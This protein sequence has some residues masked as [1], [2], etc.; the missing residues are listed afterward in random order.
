MSRGSRSTTS[1]THRASSSPTS[2][3]QSTASSPSIHRSAEPSGCPERGSSRR[4]CHASHRSCTGGPDRAH[5]SST[6]STGSPTGRALTRSA[7]CWSTCRAGSR[8]CWLRERCPTCRSGVCARTGACSRSGAPSWRSTRRRHRRWP[9]VS[10]TGSS[11]SR[12]RR[13]RIAPRGGRRPSSWRRWDR[14]ETP[15]LRSARSRSR[16]ATGT[17]PSTCG[18]SCG[19]SSTTATSRC[20][21]GRRSSTWSSPG[22]PSRSPAS[23]T[24]ASGCGGWPARTCSSARLAALRRHSGITTS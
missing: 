14:C 3:R 9:P 7:R 18:P 11:P 24:P 6:T 21:P 22:S 15:L 20:S 2:P 13:W 19:P 12:P 5:W 8:W 4:P 1:T 16:G 23:P 10:D 17:L